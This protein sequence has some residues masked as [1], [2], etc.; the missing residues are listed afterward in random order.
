MSRT[1]ELLKLPGAETAALFSRKGLLEEFEGTLTEVEAVGMVNLCTAITMTMEMQGR[2]L[3]RLAGKP[4]WDS[5]YGWMTW[6]PEMSIVTV[7]DSVC[8]V[9]GRK[10]SFNQVI[11]AMTE[12]ADTEVIKPGGK[13]EPNASIG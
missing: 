12:S 4:G 11:K 9:R 5:F 6:G 10:T 8:I 13:G 2:L 1:S 7:H 3:N